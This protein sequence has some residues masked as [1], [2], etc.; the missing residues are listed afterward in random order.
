MPPDNPMEEETA[1]PSKRSCLNTGVVD[2][3]FEGVEVHCFRKSS[4]QL[5]ELVNVKGS[6]IMKGLVAEESW[7]WI[8]GDDIARDVLVDGSWSHFLWDD[9]KELYCTI[10]VRQICFLL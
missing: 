10:G 2:G 1:N 7:E 3:L 5:W 4:M 8:V 9:L 6:A